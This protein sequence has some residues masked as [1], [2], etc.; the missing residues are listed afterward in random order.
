[1]PP[2]ISPYLLVVTKSIEERLLKQHQRLSVNRPVSRK[3]SQIGSGMD[4]LHISWRC[5]SA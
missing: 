3:V 4:G 2:G 5:R 1:M